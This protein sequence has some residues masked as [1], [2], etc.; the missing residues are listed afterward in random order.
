[1]KKII[2]IIF[3]VLAF[4]S[5]HAYNSGNTVDAALYSYLKW[6]NNMSGIS[7]KKMSEKKLHQVHV[8]SADKTSLDMY[9]NKI[10]SVYERLFR[11]KPVS[12]ESS[13]IVKGYIRSNYGKAT[14]SDL[15]S[16]IRDQYYFE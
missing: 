11:A 4:G 3:T 10:V 7:F 1:M 9:A 13:A 8:L 16:V 15:A 14:V 5:A 6:E 12:D 2:F